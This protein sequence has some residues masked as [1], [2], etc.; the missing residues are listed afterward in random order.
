MQNEQISNDIVFKEGSKVYV[1]QY[2]FNIYD[3]RTFD[4]KE[5]RHKKLYYDKIEN[6]IADYRSKK[7]Q[8]F[9]GILPTTEN[10]KI[11]VARCQEV[12]IDQLDILL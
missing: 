1:L 11:Y 3:V 10:F 4:L 2:D 6:L 9:A 12:N 7:N 5:V 8:L